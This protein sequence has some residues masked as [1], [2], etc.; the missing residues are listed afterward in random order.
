MKRKFVATV[1]LSLCSIGFGQGVFHSTIDLNVATYAQTENSGRRVDRLIQQGKRAYLAGHFLLAKALFRQATT[2]DPQSSWAHFGHARTAHRLHEF[3]EAHA[4]Y[5]KALRLAPEN[6]QFSEGYMSALTWGGVYK[7]DRRMLEKA[8]DQGLKAL[9]S[10][11]DNGAIH[12]SVLKA[13]EMLNETSN[14]LVALE[15]LHARRPDSPVLA[16]HLTELRLRLARRNKD[17]QK[18]GEIE[19]AIKSELAASENSQAL[20]NRDSTAAELYKITLSYQLLGMQDK[21]AVAFGALTRSTKGRELAQNIPLPYWPGMMSFFTT[22]DL[23]SENLQLRL[24]KIRAARERVPP[25][26]GVNDGNLTVL[27]GFEFDTLAESARRRYSADPATN[28]R[29]D[30]LSGVDLSALVTIGERMTE[31]E[32]WEGANW[33]V[34]SSQLLFDLNTR[35]RDLIRLTTKGIKALSER[36]PGMINPGLTASD[37]DSAYLRYLARLKVLKGNALERMAKLSQAEVLLRAAVKDD[38]SA[39][40]YTALG[41]FL[42]R[43]NKPK[44]AYDDLV[45]ALAQPL[46]KGTPLEKQTREAATEA[47]TL[48]KKSEAIL[49]AD[50]IARKNQFAIEEEQRL[51]TDRVNLPAVDFELPDLSGRIWRLKDLR[52]NIVVLN[53]WAT[54]CVPCVAELSQFQKLVKEYVS[55]RDV[56]FLAISV[57]NSPQQVKSWIK[58]KGFDFNVLMDNQSAVD[59]KVNSYP[60]GFILASDGT[61]VYRTNGFPGDA[62][63]LKEMRLRIEALSK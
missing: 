47:A 49:S 11:P 2:V 19:S 45:S 31:L 35:T 27:L 32:T 12:Y 52:G 6:E 54:W 29:R 3:D 33:F 34:K 9:A 4:A 60:T 10:W 61:A 56:I 1:V 57:D 37:T 43:R 62:R 23:K 36:R 13:E 44:E 50:V 63:Y 21:F 41:S 55:R 53:Y 26:M 30:A 39:H 16:V 48:L 40:S 46:E 28:A 58:D 38:P 24:D 7:A 59:Y 51:L 20:T 15:S 17:T 25:T 18:V 42:L 8:R 14:Y 5:E 22:R